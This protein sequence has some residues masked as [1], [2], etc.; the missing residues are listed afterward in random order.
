MNSQSEMGWSGG[1]ASPHEATAELAAALIP[2][3]QLLKVERGERLFSFGDAARGV[4]VILKGTLR[5][6][7]PGGPGKELMCRTAEAGSVLG[8]PAALCAHNYQFNVE[9]LEAVEAVFLETVRVNEILR[10][11]PALCMQVMGMM[12]NE[13]ESLKQ[14]RERM[15]NCHNTN[16]SLHA[17]CVQAR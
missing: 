8:M 6:W 14:T 16:C 3:G 5:A 10:Q 4:Y 12:C 9:A 13:L 15:Q 2:A 17:C 1:A 7:L 11:K